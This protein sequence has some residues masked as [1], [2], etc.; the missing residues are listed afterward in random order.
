MLRTTKSKRGKEVEALDPAETKAAVLA[1][2][3]T[4]L[5][6]GAEKTK[7]ANTSGT[8]TGDQDLSG[9][10]DSLGNPN[11]DG[12]V[13]SST[14]A[15]VRSWINITTS[16]QRELNI[17]SEDDYVLLNSDKTKT[18]S[19]NSTNRNVILN[20]SFVAGDIIYINNPSVSSGVTVSSSTVSL[21]ITEGKTNIL[22]GS[23]VAKIYC[24][25]ANTY[26]LSG[27]LVEDIIFWSGTQAAYDAIVTKSTTTIYF[28]E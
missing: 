9:K 14:I 20:D 16:F 25:A 19:V 3:N 22:K 27:D 6:T 5:V 15:G 11:A 1:N 24:I 12:K 2:A 7:I 28:I 21:Y 8:N 10:E 13:L 17:V 26:V 18:V 4:Y 23:G